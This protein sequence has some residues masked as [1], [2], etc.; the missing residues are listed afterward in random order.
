MNPIKARLWMR[1]VPFTQLKYLIFQQVARSFWGG[2]R[3]FCPQQAQIAP[4]PTITVTL[5][6]AESL[7]TR[8]S[9]SLADFL[10]QGIA[11]ALS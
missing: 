1:L 2:A 8:I 3:T 7:R 9:R 5:G 6:G 11:S 10:S 4:R